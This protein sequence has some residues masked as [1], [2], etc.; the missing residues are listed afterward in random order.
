MPAHSR[1]TN[2]NAQ[3]PSPFKSALIF[4]VPENDASLRDEARK[5]LAWEDIRDD[6][7]TV[8]R[9]DEGQRRQLDTGARKAAGDLKHAVWRTY[10]HL[11]LLGRDNALQDIDLGMVNSSAAGS[12]AELYVNRLR[13]RDEI[14]DG[15]GATTLITLSR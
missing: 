13:D 6:D 12:L 2:R 9:L 4:A 7:E 3:P 10:K 5:L 1:G 11:S 8:K 14:T 15:V